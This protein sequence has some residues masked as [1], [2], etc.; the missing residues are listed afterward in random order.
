MVFYRLFTQ[1]LGEDAFVPR[2]FRPE[3]AALKSSEPEQDEESETQSADAVE[4]LGGRVG[5]GGAGE[6]GRGRGTGGSNSHELE[7]TRWSAIVPPFSADFRAN[8]NTV[9]KDS[10]MGA[11]GKTNSLLKAT[12]ICSRFQN[13]F[14]LSS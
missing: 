7:Y 10:M 9:G 2:P 4:R 5:D 8:V 14:F 1:F 12:Y 3:F 13:T 6:R 11:L